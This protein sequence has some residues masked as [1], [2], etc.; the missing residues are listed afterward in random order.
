MFYAELDVQKLFASVQKEK[1]VF[2]E[3]PKF[4]YVRRDLALLLDKPVL[5][6][7]LE[8]AAK[9]TERHLLKEVN[10]FDV[11]EGKNL[12]EG[13]KS[14]AISFILRDDE[15]TLTD[16][17]TEGVMKRIIETYEKQFGASLRQ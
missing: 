17:I 13:K 8:A 10:L 6:A 9:K 5:Y 16:D 1:T 12:P 2:R 3:I 11:Y 15:K 4:P 14:Y 7:D